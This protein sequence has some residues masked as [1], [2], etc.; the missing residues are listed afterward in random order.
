MSS[1]TNI[2][3]APSRS[4]TAHI[5]WADTQPAA[6]QS[7]Q[8][9]RGGRQER[10]IGFRYA[11]N[12]PPYGLRWASLQPTPLSCREERHKTRKRGEEIH[13]P[14]VVRKMNLVV[15]SGQ[16]VRYKKRPTSRANNIKMGWAQ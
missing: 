15:N 12:A 6:S 14:S 4:V 13:P 1:C 5:R 9:R 2:W 8:L 10:G 16:F 3:M 11:Q 7:P